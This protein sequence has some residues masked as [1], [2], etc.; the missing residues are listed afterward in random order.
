MIIFLFFCDSVSTYEYNIVDSK[1]YLDTSKVPV[2][3]KS[4]SGQ[5]IQGE[6]GFYSQDSCL[7]GTENLRDKIWKITK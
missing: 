4:L 7:Y 6:W 1:W 3:V 2:Y 5:L